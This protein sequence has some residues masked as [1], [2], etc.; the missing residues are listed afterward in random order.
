MDT[1]WTGITSS[2]EKIVPL[3]G[4]VTTG[5]LSNELFQVIIGI[6][7]FT[8]ILGVIFSLIKLMKKRNTTTTRYGV[9]RSHNGCYSV[10]DTKTG[11]NKYISESFNNASLRAEQL[12]SGKIK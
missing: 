2:V 5:L 10:Y 7:I 11:R 1:L 4:N 12:N 3:I 9:V 8:I 6:I